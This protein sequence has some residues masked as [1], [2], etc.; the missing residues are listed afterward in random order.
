ME[1]KIAQCKTELNFVIG[2]KEELC[3]ISNMLRRVEEVSVPNHER[4]MYFVER[5][6]NCATRARVLKEKL[7]SMRLRMAGMV[8]WPLINAMKAIMNFHSVMCYSDACK[9]RSKNVFVLT[10][11]L[12]LILQNC[13]H[14]Y[15]PAITTCVTNWH[16]ANIFYHP[17]IKLMEEK[18]DDFMYWQRHI[19][20]LTPYE[21]VEKIS[22]EVFFQ[23]EILYLEWV[24]INMMSSY[25]K[26]NH[27]YSAEF[28]TIF[29]TNGIGCI[30]YSFLITEGRLHSLMAKLPCD[31]KRKLFD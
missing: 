14:S 5:H 29:S 13:N 3:R 24:V 18:I 7:K 19:V 25:L 15:F 2:N 11:V 26:W 6:E 20:S 17:I 8:F 28:R 12:L 9:I 23:Y 10:D 30:I 1:E 21:V 16:A 27:R 31:K 22:T 4:R